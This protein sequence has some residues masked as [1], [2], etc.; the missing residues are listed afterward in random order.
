M[1]PGSSPRCR[2]YRVRRLI[3]VSAGVIAAFL[4][5]CGIGGGLRE[6]TWGVLAIILPLTAFAILVLWSF[7]L[8]IGSEGFRYRVMIGSWDVAF[9]DVCRALVFAANS[10]SRRVVVFHVQRKNGQRVNI[11]WDVFPTEAVAVLFT[12]LEAHG[13][14]IQVA[15]DPL[16]RQM[17]DRVRAAQARLREEEK[18]TS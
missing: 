1:E 4:A 6:G 8:E 5:V 10:T 2:V 16:A 3:G 9:T 14:P 18:G 12:A 13:I 7:R 11:Q 15:D 17:A